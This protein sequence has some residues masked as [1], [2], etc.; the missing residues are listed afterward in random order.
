MRLIRPPGIE[1]GGDEGAQ[2]QWEEGGD[3][4]E[5]ERDRIE[6]GRQMLWRCTIYMCENVIMES[7][8]IINK[9]NNKRSKFTAICY[10]FSP[11]ERVENIFITLIQKSSKGLMK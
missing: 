10:K 8:Y 9:Y 2:A 11:S 3:Y 5:W 7:V 1:R 6:Y 4:R